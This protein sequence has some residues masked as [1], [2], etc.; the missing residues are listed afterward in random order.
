MDAGRHGPGMSAHEPVTETIAIHSLNMSGRLRPANEGHVRSLV[1]AL[2]ETPPVLVRRHGSQL[3]DGFMRVDAARSVGQT[4]VP[5][6]WVDG[7]EADA[8]ERAVTT[9][10]RHGLPLSARQRREAALRLLTLAPHWSDRRVAS[11]VGVDPRSVGRWRSTEG[12]PGEEMP[13]LDAAER[14]GR[15]GRR[16]PS[17]A[18]SEAR[19]GVARV[20]LS[21]RPHLSEREVAF[22]A[23][24][25]STTVGRLRTDRLPAGDLRVA[26]GRPGGA[27]A[28]L[29]TTLGGLARR[30]AALLRSLLRSR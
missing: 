18:E 30:A 15:D 1:A 17:P 26:Q 12:R 11:A 2:G 22:R 7:D 23:G 25:S 19:R 20:L 6:E 8:W 16:Y 13:H 24:L 28:R 14:V 27:R 5:V 29:L 3:L 4:Y 9:N 10:A 21:E